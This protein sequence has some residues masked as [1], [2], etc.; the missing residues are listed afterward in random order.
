MKAHIKTIT[1]FQMNQ[2][3]TLS[4]QSSTSMKDLVLREYL[5]KVNTPFIALSSVLSEINSGA[6]EKM[7][8]AILK[9]TKVGI[10]TDLVAKLLQ[11]MYLRVVVYQDH[12][13]KG[14]RQ[15]EGNEAMDQYHD[16]HQEIKTLWVDYKELLIST[17]VKVNQMI[18][19]SSNL[20]HELAVWL[21]RA[22]TEYK[23]QQTLNDFAV[24]LVTLYGITC[25]QNNRID[26]DITPHKK[27]G[28]TLRLNAIR[29][30]V[31]RNALDGIRTNTHQL[32]YTRFFPD[33]CRMFLDIPILRNSFLGR[34][35]KKE[36]YSFN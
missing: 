30:N 19:A 21:Y 24:I 31:F 28:T 18:E 14:T 11:Y 26:D 4:R 32:I 34:R 9:N 7:S 17:F 6:F 3:L 15:D 36:I 8:N 2:E 35:E 22:Y 12:F 29:S 20:Y 5:K 27:G 13:T 25:N 16:L 33:N 1:K 10:D 23:V